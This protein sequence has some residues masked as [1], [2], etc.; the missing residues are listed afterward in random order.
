MPSH[1]CLPREG[2]LD[3]I[4]YIF[5]YFKHKHNGSRVFDPAYS[6]IDYNNFPLND[7]SNFYGKTKEIL[8]NNA[9]DPRGKGP[10]VIVYVEADLAG[11]RVTRLSRTG[12][13][14]YLIQAPE[15]WFLKQQN[16]VK[17]GTF[18]SEFVAIKQCCEYI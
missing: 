4:F 6:V 8:P 14:I 12:F 18:G 17:A 9:P 7:Q 15:Y 10:D 3:K 1:V 2:H 11:N 16:G 5:A 13:V